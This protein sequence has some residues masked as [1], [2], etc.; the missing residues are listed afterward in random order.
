MG[1]ADRGG[2]VPERGP[3]RYCGADARLLARVL[4]TRCGFEP[5]RVLVIADDQTDPGNLPF[6][7]NLVVKIPAWL[8]LARPDD[9]VI[10]MFSGHGFLDPRGRMYLAPLDCD[11]D[12]LPLTGLAVDH[13]RDYL[14]NCKA[15][16]KLLILDTCH[17]GAAKGGKAI[18]VEA[19]TIGRALQQA[20]QDG[21]QTYTIHCTLAPAE[22]GRA[23]RNR[24][25]P[26]EVAEGSG[27][28]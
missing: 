3:L 6:R 22:G 4:T 27:L 5:Q 10:V 11:P 26:R 24:G 15:R 28:H 18:G 7:S 1:V 14:S 16:V 23:A 19:E 2:Q 25:R 20:G 17:S 12:N 21:G 8:K 9:R 13:L